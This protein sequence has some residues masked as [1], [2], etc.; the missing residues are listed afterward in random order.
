MKRICSEEEDLQNKLGNLESWLVSKGYRAESV[1][2][3]IQRVNSIDLQVF[4]QK[5]PKI[6]ED[7][8][9]SI[10]IF[11]PALCIIWEILKSA[12][13]ILENSPTL[14]AILPKPPRVAFRNPKTL[15]DKLVRSKLDQIVRRKEV[16]L[17]VAEGTATFAISY[18][19]S[20]WIKKYNHWG[21][22]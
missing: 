9:T 7:S 11:H 6:Q 13:W 3:E 5:C 18:R 19:A 2:R 8:L 17:F 22:M 21:S 4:L 15:G 20:E 16:F 12:H 14:K 1:R 10:L